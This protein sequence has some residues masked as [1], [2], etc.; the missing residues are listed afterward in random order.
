G[1]SLRAAEDVLRAEAG[2][3]EGAQRSGA[4]Y[5][6]AYAAWK[7]RDLAQAQQA[8]QQARAQGSDAPQI[9]GLEVAIMQAQGNNERALAL[10]Q[11]AARRWPGSQGVALA[12]IEAL[13]GS[14]QHERAVQVMTQRLEQWPEVPRL[15]QLQSQSLE[16][17]GR[18]A[19][20]R[21]SMA[22]YYELTGAL[23]AAVEQLQQA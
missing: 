6:L 5:G 10:A 4:W 8:L 19:E 14:G 1:Q 12:Q 3:S 17:L 18:A 11:E 22:T 9:A 2:K 7:R 21:R 13:Q 16:R 23:P 20:A 15:W